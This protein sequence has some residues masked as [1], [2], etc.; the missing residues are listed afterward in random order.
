[1]LRLHNRISLMS[2][3]RLPKFIYDWDIS[4]GLDSWAYQVQQVAGSLGLPTRLPPGG[5]YD[6]AYART[7]LLEKCRLSW[8]L[9]A[10]RKPKLRTFIKI[11]D[12]NQHKV[13]TKSNLSRYQRS[14]LSQLKLGILP[15]KIETD[16][17]QGIPEHLRLCQVCNSGSIE[18]EY[19][20][21][22]HCPGLHEV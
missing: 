2:N 11:H 18:N 16:R 17:Y 8:A 14:L 15:L 19:H 4:L 3:E 13:I 12:F 6:L 5:Q 7:K 9:E 20:F 22:F 1:M 21:L 10:E